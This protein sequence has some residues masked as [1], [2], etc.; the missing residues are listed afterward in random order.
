MNRIFLALMALL[1]GLC[2]QVAPTAARVSEDTQIGAAAHFGA[3]DRQ[4]TKQSAVL[5]HRPSQSC[6]FDITA[7]QIA[8]GA[9]VPAL[10]GVLI[11]IDR[12]RE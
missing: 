7:A 6:A 10:P 4:A 3:P 8:L 11:R 5:A 9:Q 12:T 2:T 1:A